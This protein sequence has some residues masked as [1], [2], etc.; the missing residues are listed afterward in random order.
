VK[1]KTGARE[2]GMA[3][4]FKKN[5]KK[6]TTKQNSRLFQEQAMRVDACF[7]ILFLRLLKAYFQEI[8]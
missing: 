7:I 5:P 8:A 3:I 4:S 1:F 6:I 2:L